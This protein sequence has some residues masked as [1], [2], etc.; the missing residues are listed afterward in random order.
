MRMLRKIKKIRPSL[1]HLHN[2]HNSYVNLPMLFRY[3]KK[4]NVPVVWTLH[5]C[6]A[7]TGHCPHFVM[8]K[9]DRWQSG[10]G[11]CPLYKQYPH[12]AFDNTKRMY[13]LKKKWFTG[14]EN[15]TI[16]TPSQW[17]ADLVKQSFLKDY[18]VKVIHNGIDLSVFR[19]I[20]NDFRQKYH[21]EEK[22][23]IL[24][25]AFGW[26]AR[27][28]L[29]VFVELITFYPMHYSSKCHRPL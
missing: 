6:W 7:F 5:D 28:G 29:D 4:H 10:C 21:C 2:L 13:Q 8:A 24:G 27:K 15:M 19:P 18:P 1:I 9:C 14:V 12:L 20:E 11:E 22:K 25:V 17:L 23:V 26:G 3:I 16:V